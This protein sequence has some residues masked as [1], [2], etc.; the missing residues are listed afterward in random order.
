MNDQAPND[1]QPDAAQPKP[2]NADWF[3]QDL[4]KLTNTT[5]GAAAFGVTLCVKG[6]MVSGVIASGRDYFN[7][8]AQNVAASLPPDTEEGTRKNFHTYFA[9]YGEIYPAR[10][11]AEGSAKGANDAGADEDDDAKPL[12]EFIHLRN[13]RIFNG[14]TFT[15]TQGGI[16]WRGR[17]SEIDGWILGM[18]G[19]TQS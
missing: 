16:W 14:E 3:L 12:P 17:I 4:V 9:R 19:R 5:A 2:A 1:Q 10:D 15:P 13:A 8:F 7:N 11:D 6:I 18:L